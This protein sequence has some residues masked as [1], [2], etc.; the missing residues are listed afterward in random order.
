MYHH[1][2]D[3][4]KSQEKQFRVSKLPEVEEELRDGHEK[5]VKVTLVPERN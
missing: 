2:F 5:S 1:K 4:K 3:G